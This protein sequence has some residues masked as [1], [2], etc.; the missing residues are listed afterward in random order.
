MHEPGST[1]TPDPVR[2]PVDHARDADFWRRLLHRWI[3]EYN[4]SYLL[5]AALVLFGV[6]LISREL[7][8]DSSL[9]GK[10]G[11]AVIAEAYAIA[12][13]A[14]AAV[15]TRIELR[16]PAVM[17]GL[18]AV[19]YQGDL[20]LHVETSAYLGTVGLFASALWWVLFVAKLRALAWAL[21]LRLSR[22]AL[23]VP[24]LGALGLAAIPHCLRELDPD[25]GAAVVCLWLFF[26]F[27]GGLFTS[28]AVQSAVG[29]DIRGRRALRATWGIWVALALG[30][31]LY[32]ASEHDLSLAALMPAAI[33]LGARWARRELHVWVAVAAALLGVTVFLPSLTSITALMAAAMLVMRALR[34]PSASTDGSAPVLAPPY[35]S[36]NAP[37]DASLSLTTVFGRADHGSMNRLLMGGLGLVYVSVWTLGWD[38]GQLPSHPTGLVLLLAAGSAVCVWRSRRALFLTPLAPVGIHLLV[39]LGWIGAPRGAMQWGT[40]AV[41]LGFSILLG[42]VAASWVLRRGIKSARAASWLPRSADAIPRASQR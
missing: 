35:R 30:H 2:A 24:T 16:R 42:S 41:G 1:P 22:S 31:A 18:L 39:Q 17:L 19:L 6:W 4:P 11:V 9:F 20:T 32:S 3:L 25:Q 33:L 34:S 27:C 15:L 26:L 8:H 5:S 40:T 21:E 13:I 23:L 28:R 10:L 37:V 14:G 29:F 12:L 36:S 7:A 38:G